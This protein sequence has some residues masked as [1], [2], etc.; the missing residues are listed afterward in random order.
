DRRG[1]DR[2]RVLHARAALHLRLRDGVRGSRADMSVEA[3]PPLPANPG[4]PDRQPVLSMHGISKSFGKVQALTDIHLDIHPGEV[5]AIVGDT[6]AGKSTLVK[7]LAGVHPAD[8]GEIEV[9]GMPAN[10]PYPTL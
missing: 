8:D 2:R 4:P 9:D 6:G 1:R 10:I 3:V 5:V 7:I